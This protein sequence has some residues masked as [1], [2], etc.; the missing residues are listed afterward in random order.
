M[1]T[2][3]RQ[4]SLGDDVH[5]ATLFFFFLGAVTRPPARFQRPCCSGPWRGGGGTDG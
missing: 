5:P 2:W 3:R 4:S 1:F